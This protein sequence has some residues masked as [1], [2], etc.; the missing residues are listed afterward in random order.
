MVKTMDDKLMCTLNNDKLN[1]SFCR[2]KLMVENLKPTNQDTKKMYEKTCKT[3]GNNKIYI[4]KS[5]T[6]PSIQLLLKY[7]Q[8]GK[9]CS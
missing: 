8:Q 6:S 9:L 4:P 2:L 1:H 7:R 5:P 3:L